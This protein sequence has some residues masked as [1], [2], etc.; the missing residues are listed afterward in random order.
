MTFC[1][2]FHR[3]L[4]STEHLACPGWAMGRFAVV[5]PC[6][7]QCMLS[8]CMLLQG[9][10]SHAP[11]Q[12]K[13]FTQPH[14]APSRTSEAFSAQWFHEHNPEV[15]AGIHWETGAELLG[16]K[17]LGHFTHFL[18]PYTDMKMNFKQNR[19]EYRW[20]T[21]PNVQPWPSWHLLPASSGTSRAARSV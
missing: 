9:R 1:C 12:N 13:I 17:C 19:D 16:W 2:L 7:M 20:V 10:E 8:V 4:T 5:K 6:C 11:I 3:G 21:I 14:M 15:T 18:R